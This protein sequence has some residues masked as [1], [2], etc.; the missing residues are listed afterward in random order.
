V[1]VLADS[2]YASA[3]D[4]VDSQK[5]GLDL[6]APYQENDRTQQRRAA[7]PHRQIPKSEFSWLPEEQT[8]VC[9]QGHRLKRIGQEVRDRAQER[10]VEMTIY[11]CPKDHCQNCPLVGQCTWGA[12]GRTIKRNEHE[13]LIVAHQAKMET[14][15]AKAIYKQRGQTVELRFADAKTHRG[16]RRFS[17]R[18]LK[19]VRIEV[20][21]FAPSAFAPGVPVFHQESLSPLSL[22]TPNAIGPTRHP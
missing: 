17:S 4:L 5:A 18:G 1:Q 8:Y 20:G 9:P 12:N 19:R 15:E 22:R 14:V 2:T 21:L 11:R 10:T 3:L 16:F 7:K 13:D 6:Y